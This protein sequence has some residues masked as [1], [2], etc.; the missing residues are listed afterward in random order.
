[1]TKQ[2][3]ILNQNNKSELI[4]NKIPQSQ[5]SIQMLPSVEK[6]GSEKLPPGMQNNYKMQKPSIVPNVPN[7]GSQQSNPI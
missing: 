1:M 5:N 6:I 7:L 4:N 2:L 3:D